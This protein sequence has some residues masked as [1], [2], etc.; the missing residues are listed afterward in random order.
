MG[1]RQII[2]FLH[3]AQDL[4]ATWG[5]NV[6]KEQCLIEMDSPLED[7]IDVQAALPAYDF[8]S[9]A[10]PTFTIGLSYHPFRTDLILKQANNVREHKE[11]RPF[12]IVDVTYETGD[13]LNTSPTGR[14]KAPTRI[15]QNGGTAA[16]PS[17]IIVAPWNEPVI[18]HSS[19]RSV[20]T[21][22]YKDSAGNTLLH[23]NYMP[24]TEGV[25]IPI[26]LQVHQFT[27][28]VMATGFNYNTDIA[29]YI[30]KINSAVITDFYSAAIKHVLCESITCT[31]N[32]KYVSAGTPV[33]QANEDGTYHYIT[34][35]A[36][37]VIDERTAIVSPQGYFREANRRVSMHTQQ[38]VDDGLGNM[39]YGPIPINDRGDVAKSPWPLQPDGTAYP[40]G[41]MNIAD[42]DVD[43][44]IIDPLFPIEANLNTF[45]VAHSL[46]IP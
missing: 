26:N 34:I 46:A 31:E 21:T 14:G 1:L 8:G 15:K 9:T 6:V 24:L 7:V 19:S 39:A 44:A 36:V 30:G 22:R 41:D 18:W 2:G 28:N 42:P 40:Y 5:V 29:P 25:D 43:F 38:I 23:A 11:G 17:E 13:W 12:W 4:S 20:Q 16:V 32:Y 3:E 10:E 37:F 45:V 33:G 35:S 27:W